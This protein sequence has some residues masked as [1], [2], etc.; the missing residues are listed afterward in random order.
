[1]SVTQ[2]VGTMNDA[3]ARDFISHAPAG[4]LCLFDGK[5]PYAVPVEHYLKGEHLYILVSPR[6]DQRKI[7]C[8][9]KN[10]DACFV[11]YDSRRETPDLVKKGIRCRS[12]IIEG[13]VYLHDIKEI[14]SKKGGG[15]I[16]IQRLRFDI[17]QIGNWT[18]PGKTCDWQSAWFERYP[19]LVADL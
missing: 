4:V 11:I 16:K 17:E 7:E 14:E 19:D 10:P 5:R 18:C 13:R 12:V 2:G 3:Q 6:E 15:K 8:I 9:K 1:M